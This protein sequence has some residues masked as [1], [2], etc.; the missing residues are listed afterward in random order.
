MDSL[1]SLSSELLLLPSSDVERKKIE[2]RLAALYSTWDQIC[3]QVRKGEE[4]KG[5][6]GREGRGGGRRE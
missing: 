3:Q 5:G 1:Q 2:K 4:E 6:V